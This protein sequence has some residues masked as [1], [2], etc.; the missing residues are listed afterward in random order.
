M[1]QRKTIKLLGDSGFPAAR[2]E[3]RAHPS[4]VGK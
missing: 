4:L 3:A 2:S 1:V